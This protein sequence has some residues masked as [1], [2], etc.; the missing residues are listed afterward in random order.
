MKKL[1]DYDFKN[2][3]AEELNLLI[4]KNKCA[5]YQEAL[6]QI[7]DLLEDDYFENWGE[8]IELAH[9]ALRA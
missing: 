4:L 2:L 3:S 8:C 6:K 5:I 9:D 1:L 7:K